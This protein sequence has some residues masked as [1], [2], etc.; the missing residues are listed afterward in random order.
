MLSNS[1]YKNMDAIELADRIRN[2][3]FTAEEVSGCAIARAKETNPSINAIVHENY[4]NALEQARGFDAKPELLKQSNLAGLPFL[5]KDLST[6]KGLPASFGSRLFDGYIASSSS[7]IVQKYLDAGLIVI[8]KTN[9]P[10]WGLTLT[11]EPQSNVATRNP[12]NTDYSTGGSSGGAAAAVA[13]GIVPVAH[14]SDGGGSIRI[15]AACCGVFGLKPSR[16]LTTIE[17]SLG[18]CWSGM[19][20]GHVVSQTVR[21]SAA[22][23]DLIKLSKPNLFPLPS[24]PTSF[25]DVHNGDVSKLRIGIQLT[26][27][28]DQKIDDECIRGVKIAAEICEALG[29]QVEEFTHPVNYFRTSSAMGTLI[30]VHV[31]QAVSPRL[32][33]LGVSLEDSPI[34]TST[35]IMASHGSKVTASDYLAARDKIKSAE[36]QME[37]LHKKY[38]IIISPVLSKTPAKIGWLD[39]N[40]SDMKQYTN[41]FKAY[42]GFSALYNGTGQP[43]MSMPLH[44]TDNGVPVGVM[45]TAA[46][47]GDSLLLQLAHKIELAKP[48]A[49][50]AN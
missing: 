8:G 7:N 29:H 31:Y 13:A 12:W 15:P 47:G 1:D 50:T 38:D 32:E 25:F 21:D 2:K 11:T 46:W 22:F 19:S 17:N 40:S 44:Q 48:W 16:G 4:E 24:S 20:V 39:M 18:E 10:E 33:E 34:E 49:R 42:S 43:S 9:T 36:Y 27:P 37:E 35:R 6:V 26:H 3:D 14:A 41:R 28:M 5:I 45:F 23:L 30:N